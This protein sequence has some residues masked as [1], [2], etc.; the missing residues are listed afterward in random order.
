VGTGKTGYSV[1]VAKG[2]KVAQARE[3][4]I[5]RIKGAFVFIV[6]KGE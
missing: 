4:R 5:N 1:G 3:R 6:K 2:L